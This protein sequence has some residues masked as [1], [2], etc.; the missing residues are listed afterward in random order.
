MLYEPITIPEARMIIREARS[1][2]TSLNIREVKEQLPDEE[3]VKL[4]HACE[5]LD[6]VNCSRWLTGVM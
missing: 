3:R 1:L 2:V 4:V 5:L 6:R